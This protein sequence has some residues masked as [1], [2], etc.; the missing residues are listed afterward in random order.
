[1]L[2]M[3]QADGGAGGQDVVSTLVYN[4]LWF[5]VKGEQSFPSKHLMLIMKT[6]EQCSLRWAVLY[7]T[8]KTV[9]ATVSEWPYIHKHLNDR[10]LIVVVIL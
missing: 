6:N 7:F 2:L 1:M 8:V 5:A 9:F 4:Q 3:R 10:L